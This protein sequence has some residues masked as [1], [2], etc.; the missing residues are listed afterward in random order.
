MEAEVLRQRA[1]MRNQIISPA[2]AFEKE[3]PIECSSPTLRTAVARAMGFTA[4]LS[5]L[6]KTYLETAGVIARSTLDVADIAKRN[7]CKE[8]ARL[9]Y[10]LIL[11][12]YVGTAYA[13]YRERAIVGINDLRHQN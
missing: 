12:T 1:E 6:K 8:H 9:L 10:D 7:K 3:R 2:L 13:A 4:A 5:S 11:E